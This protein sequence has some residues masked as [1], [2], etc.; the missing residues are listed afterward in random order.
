MLGFVKRLLAGRLLATRRRRMSVLLSAVLV[1]ALAAYFIATAF[2]FTGFL[3]I[4]STGQFE[5]DGNAVTDAATPPPYDWDKV[6]AQ[7]G[8][9]S[10]STSVTCPST[11]PGP[12]DGASARAFIFDPVN[13]ASDDIF[14]GG[15]SKDGLP[16]D[17]WLWKNA[18]VGQPKDDLEHAYAVQ[19]QSVKECSLSNA[20]DCANHQLLF[21]GT[22]RFS[23]GGASDVGFWFLKS[24]VA[25]TQ[26]KSGGGMTF[27]GHHS[28]GDVL[29]LSTFTNGGTLPT[30]AVFKWECPGLTGAACDSAASQP[31]QLA[32][33]PAI[34]NP[35]PANC[36]ATGTTPAASLPYCATVNTAD[37]TKAPWPYT[38][39]SADHNT[40]GGF[41]NATFF[42]G[43][44]D[45]THLGLDNQCFSSFVTE[46]R[47]SQSL[48]ATLSDIVI[49]G[50]A[51]CTAS[52]TTK[53]T[54]TGNLT[55]L[56]PGTSVT[57]TATV[58][59]H[60]LASP[61]FPTSSTTSGDSGAPGTPVT[62]TLC[63]P[64]SATNCTTLTPTESL[65][66][67]ANAGVSTATS[68]SVAPTTPGKYC[69]HASWGG[70]ANYIGTITET[71]SA[72][73]CFTVA[74]LPT[75]TV[76]KPGNGSGAF[77]STNTPV[78]GA[79]AFDTAVVTAYTDGTFTTQTG[80]G[81][82]PSGTVTFYSCTPAQ[83][84]AASATT[85][86]SSIGT[87]VGSAGVATTEVGS[88]PANPAHS[89]S[90]ATS[91]PGVTLDKAGTWCF[92]AYYVPGPPNGAHFVSTG[93]SDA[94]ATE[95]FTVPPQPT[96]TVT[97]PVD[98]S[99]TNLNKN[100]QTLTNTGGIT[101]YDSAVV[102]G[103]AGAG[104]PSGTVDFSICGPVAT[105]TCDAST[106]AGTLFS[107]QTSASAGT[108]GLDSAG[109][110]TWTVRSLSTTITNVGT[111]CFYAKYTPDTANYTGSRD[112]SST[113]C[114]TIKD[115]ATSSSFQSWIP[116]D[117]ATIGANGGTALHGTLKFTLYPD[118]NCN[119]G[120]ADLSVF[121]EEFTLAGA[122]AGTSVPTNGPNPA[123]VT[124]PTGVTGSVPTV[125]FLTPTNY[126]WLVQFASSDGLVAS[127]ADRCEHTA[128]TIVN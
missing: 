120:G 123:N 97:T 105:G 19:Y 38:E 43:G 96:A 117:L 82:F 79:S 73:E 122:S 18:K 21:F 56:V 1:P 111:Y 61:P 75:A 39:A 100:T 116:S 59:G 47:A 115:Q 68:P 94:T 60:G 99:G 13:S 20:T 126:S 28:D 9:T 36:L 87:R 22:D 109:N 17:G 14:T 121:H 80:A 91:S 71:N 3:P 32:P 6:Y 81:G 53:P 69:F 93:S 76:T 31:T 46:S 119:S 12:I 70:D 64:D 25:E 110:P 62:F 24:K 48:S 27:A 103:A 67:T 52:M 125:T 77:T 8:G 50:F 45:L 85:C 107:T 40:S 10:T 78:L 127:P 114:F 106:S 101:V 63:G 55:S 41:G 49:G 113:E 34:T 84:A 2:G 15:A 98:G 44:V 23:N 89:Q 7:C 88:P 57:D 104:N 95:C 86:S 54:S 33:D 124:G 37:G 16:I 72:D 42:E 90:T 29:V 35:P 51:P 102:T 74:P 92:A 4:Q 58:T 108:F 66:P 11:N 128:L 118:L 112:G 5:L 83:L 30:V 26:T 65:S